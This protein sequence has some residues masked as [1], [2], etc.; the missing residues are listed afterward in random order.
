MYFLSYKSVQTE[1]KNIL[2]CII[3]FMFGVFCFSD[4]GTIVQPSSCHPHFWHDL[5]FLGLSWLNAKL[6]ESA[7]D[8]NENI[9][10]IMKDR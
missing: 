9:V 5:H 6:D 8:S 10:L 2:V 7:G 4:L 3:L 1:E